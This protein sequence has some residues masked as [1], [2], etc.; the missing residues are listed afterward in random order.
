[1]NTKIIK[2]DREWKA[3]LNP[4]QFRVTRRKGTEAPFSGLYHNHKEVGNYLCICCR[5]RL[6]S[7]EHKFDSGTGWPSYWQPIEP[8]VVRE[9]QDR[10]V[11][12]QR[13]AVTCSRCD[14]HL[15]HVF[16][17]GPAPTYLRY[18]INSAAISFQPR[19]GRRASNQ[20]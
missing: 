6:F 19:S 4:E 7:S 1:M 14:A 5:Q 10:S 11:G 13:T 20:S 18:C 8:S 9:H 2:T 16:E 3:Q 15:G 17:D 12:M